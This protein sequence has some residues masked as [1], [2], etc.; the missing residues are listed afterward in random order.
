MLRIR[1]SAVP[2]VSACQASARPPAIKIA[3]SSG[4][5][6][7]LGDALHEAQSL[8]VGLDAAVDS[9]KPLAQKHR[10]DA[11]ELGYLC[12]AGRKAWDT[13]KGYFSDP[14]CEEDFSW[15]D[16][17]SQIVLTGHP[18]V[19]SANLDNL[20]IADWKSG[21]LWSDAEP[22]LRAYAWLIAQQ[23]PVK[24][25]TAFHVNIRRDEIERFDWTYDELAAWWHDLAQRITNEQDTYSPSYEACR[26]CPRFHE[27]EA[28]EEFA[29][30]EIGILEAGDY[31]IT[32]S[33]TMAYQRAKF[34]IKI[35]E[36]VVESLRTMTAQAGGS[37]ADESGELVL[38]RQ[39]REKIDAQRGW[40]TITDTLTIHETLAACTI[41]KTKLMESVKAP[42]P[43]GKKKEVA[44]ELMDRI[45]A[46]G[47]VSE[48]FIEKLEL[49]KA[50]KL[51]ASATKLIE[52]TV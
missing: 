42:A 35:A 33:P 50:P 43:R 32:L 9:P 20:V 12:Y 45:R 40:K 14:R 6:A 52:Q 51:A 8:Y 26:Y 28:G 44:D 5:P 46:A 15:I 39:R 27:C 22:Q 38:E 3:S 37:L 21:F 7:R 18:D 2:Q 41:S 48:T 31:S 4:E 49:R 1:S 25:I 17:D 19:Y 47:A 10:V 11:E 24:T 29:R 16:E 30:K 36:G 34:L 13:I 23:F